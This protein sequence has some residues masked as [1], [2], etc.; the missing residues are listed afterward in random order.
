M[1]GFSVIFDSAHLWALTLHI[2]SFA[3]SL[4]EMDCASVIYSSSVTEVKT[5]INDGKF[6][7][8][9]KRHLFTIR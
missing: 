4:V 5:V 1:K 2:V 8:G 7:V 6:R 9:K 3:L